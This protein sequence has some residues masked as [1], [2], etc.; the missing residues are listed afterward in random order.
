MFYEK[1][2]FSQNSFV[3]FFVF[4]FEK[5]CVG[6]NRGLWEDSCIATQERRDQVEHPP[7][8]ANGRSSPDRRD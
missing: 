4:F 7:M 1:I 3:D 6:K 5:K 2:L 8:D